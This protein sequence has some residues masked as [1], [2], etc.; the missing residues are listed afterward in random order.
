MLMK[1]RFSYL[2]LFLLAGLYIDID[3]DF[4]WPNQ[5]NQCNG[6]FLQRTILV[7]TIVPFRP[8]RENFYL[9]IGNKHFDHTKYITLWCDSK[10]KYYFNE[11]EQGCAVER[12][13]ER[14]HFI[15]LKFWDS[16]FTGKTQ[17]IM[18][19]SDDR[20][21]TMKSENREM[22]EQIKKEFSQLEGKTCGGDL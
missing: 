14:T 16:T 7:Q 18:S 21:L 20:L 11:S 15:D 3:T 10:N 9:G 2:V 6:N 8:E 1:K 19:Q 12:K 17:Y 22:Y 5:W 4:D 13:R